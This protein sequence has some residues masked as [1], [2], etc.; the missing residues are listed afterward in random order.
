MQFT[1][2]KCAYDENGQDSTDAGRLPANIIA[3]S[4][5]GIGEGAGTCY[6]FM[7]IDYG[8]FGDKAAKYSE[9]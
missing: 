4:G 8:I 9:K 7:A 2:K 3:R 5:G 1:D 6:S